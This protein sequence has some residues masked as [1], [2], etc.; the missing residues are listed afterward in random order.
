VPLHVPVIKLSSKRVGVVFRRQFSSS[1]SLL[2]SLFVCGLR[3]VAHVTRAYQAGCISYAGHC[4]LWVSDAIASM[5]EEITV[6]VGNRMSLDLQGKNI[7]MYVGKD[8]TVSV[9]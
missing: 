3:D 4:A 9:G 7:K 6:S 2:S 1:G 8:V 5:S